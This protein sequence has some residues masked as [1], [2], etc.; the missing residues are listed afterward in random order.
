MF[1]NNYFLNYSNENTGESD[2]P[3]SE[4]LNESSLSLNRKSFLEGDKDENDS[5]EELWG[6]TDNS[7]IVKA[8]QHLD[9]SCFK[10][11]AQKNL[12]IVSTIPETAPNASK[13]S[14]SNCETVQST[15]NNN[16]SNKAI[17]DADHQ[18]QML[19][20]QIMSCDWD[21]DLDNGDLENGFIMGDED[22]SLI[23][24]DVLCGLDDSQN[25]NQERKTAPDQKCDSENSSDKM[26]STRDSKK[27]SDPNSPEIT[28]GCVQTD[29]ANCQTENLSEVELFNNF[30]DDEFENELILSKPEVLSWIDEVESK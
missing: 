20:T 7:F 24:D 19:L 25:K 18:A 21:S 2:V 28:F 17:L 3:T 30:E 6:E 8:T 12:G 23:P 29:S 22:F 16:F 10:H 4:G 27:Q 9:V 15:N 11:S 14:K 13:K 1:L 26:Q 5:L